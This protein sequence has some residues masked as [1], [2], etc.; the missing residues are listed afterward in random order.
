MLF[1]RKAGVTLPLELDF[2]MGMRKYQV[3]FTDDRGALSV[4]RCNLGRY[5]LAAKEKVSGAKMGTEVHLETEASLVRKMKEKAV[6]EPCSHTRQ[7]DVHDMLVRPAAGAD[8][9][10]DS[11]S[12]LLPAVVEHCSHGGAEARIPIAWDAAR[13]TDGPSEVQGR[14]DGS[15]RTRSPERKP[16]TSAKWVKSLRTTD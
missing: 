5:M 7:R 4:F 3:F 2:S 6:V 1:R 15:W 8:S 14:T 9:A 13:S 10:R 12:T 16:A 11:G